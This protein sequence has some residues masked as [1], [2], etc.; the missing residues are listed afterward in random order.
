[1]QRFF[2]VIKPPRSLATPL[3]VRL[4]KHPNGVRGVP[5]GLYS[6]TFAGALQSN[7]LSGSSPC[8]VRSRLSCS[9]AIESFRN[10]PASWVGVT[11]RSIA[12]TRMSAF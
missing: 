2:L 11:A 1:M 9:Q 6:L 10:K 4:T 7:Y 12:T 3:L 8:S 5:V